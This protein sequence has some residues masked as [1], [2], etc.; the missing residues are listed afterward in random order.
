M[1]ALLGLLLPDS[2]LLREG[3]DEVGRKIH[4]YLLPNGSILEVALQ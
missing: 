3:V 1:R 2:I 4:H